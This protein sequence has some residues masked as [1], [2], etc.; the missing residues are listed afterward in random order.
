MDELINESQLLCVLEYDYQEMFE[1]LIGHIHSIPEFITKAKLHLRT[2]D[3]NSLQML[4]HSIRGESLN[5][6]LTALSEQFKKLE[7][8]S[9]QLKTEE[10]NEILKYIFSLSNRIEKI[11]L[12]KYKKEL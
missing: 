10:I 12:E 9:E 4:A 1:L 2:D 5:F 6:G 3:F 8:E 7:Y 11:I